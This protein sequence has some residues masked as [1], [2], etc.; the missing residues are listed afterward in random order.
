MLITANNFR[1]IESIC[2]K[3]KKKEKNLSSNICNV[4]ILTRSK[5]IQQFYQ[6]CARKKYEPFYI[7]RLYGN[8]VVRDNLHCYNCTFFFLA[9]AMTVA[10]D[11]YTTICKIKLVATYFCLVKQKSISPVFKSDILFFSTFQESHKT[12]SVHKM[13]KCIFI[14]NLNNYMKIYI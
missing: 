11:M 13:Y 3:L 10:L 5:L 7:L 6:L 8:V 12:R 4:L 2:V 9:R 14:K 1:S